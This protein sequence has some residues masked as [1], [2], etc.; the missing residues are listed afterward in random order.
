MGYDRDFLDVFL[1]T[2]KAFATAD[3]LLKKL[4]ERWA[5]PKALD[6]EATQRVRLRVGVFIQNWIKSESRLGM[7][8]TIKDKLTKFIT[9]RMLDPVGKRKKENPFHK[10]GNSLLSKL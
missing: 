4:G 1:M 8:Q 10:L 2:Y 3:M 7:K 9:S 5:V 6:D